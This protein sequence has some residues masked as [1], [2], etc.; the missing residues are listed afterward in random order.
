MQERNT[1]QKQIVARLIQEAGHPLTVREILDLGRSHMSGLGIA[2]VYRTV[3][4]LLDA[5]ELQAVVIPGDTVRYE[6]VKHHHH[7]FKCNRCDRV[8]DLDGCIK[9]L[10]SMVPRGFKVENHELTFYGY[11]RSC[12]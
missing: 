5:G 8:F 3:K 11:C 7:H 2:T 1:R 6:T 12:A 9:E 10:K 4:R